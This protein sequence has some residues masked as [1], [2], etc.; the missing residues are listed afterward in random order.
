[1]KEFKVKILAVDGSLQEASYTFQLKDKAIVEDLK[2]AFTTKEPYNEPFQLR[3]SY[4]TASGKL[5]K[6]QNDKCF[7]T[8]KV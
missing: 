7:Q 5:C 3:M 4:K 1:M 6:T 8:I 2:R